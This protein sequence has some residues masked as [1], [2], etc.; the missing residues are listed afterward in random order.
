[1]TVIR[2]S[3]TGLRSTWKRILLNYQLYVFLLP[4]VVFFIIFHYYPMFGLKMAFQNFRPSLGFANSAWVGFANF[5]RL[6]SGAYFGAIVK[7]TFVLSLYF[8]LVKTPLAVVFALLLNSM[9]SKR[10]KRFIQTV[11]YAPHFISTVVLV[12]MFMLFLSPSNGIVNNMIKALGGEKVNFIASAELFPHL[13]VWTG[14]WQQLGWSAVIYFAALSSVSQDLH[15]AA[16]VDGA[17]KLKRLI[18]IDL[19]AII[20]TLVIIMILDCGRV[21]NVGFEKAFLMQNDVNA[22]TSEIIST[23]SYKTGLIKGQ[24][25]YAAAIGLFNSVV[26][27]VMIIAV[28]M[29]S[30]KLSETSLW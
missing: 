6:F 8:L 11:T 14:I 24:Y 12:G 30:R 29:A 9:P 23:Y 22:L 15:E 3:K 7:N 25:S 18:H 2:R 13:Y 19:P 17:S 20:P 5:K 21:L 4:S 28:N 26:N 1:M 10:Y 16:M 27:F